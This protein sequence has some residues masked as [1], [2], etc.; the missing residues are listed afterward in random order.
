MLYRHDVRKDTKLPEGGIVIRL[1]VLDCGRER[2]R[3]E[4]VL[5][6][7]SCSVELFKDGDDNEDNQDDGVYHIG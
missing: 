2:D 4:S 7:L 3:F 6:L 5:F 1:P